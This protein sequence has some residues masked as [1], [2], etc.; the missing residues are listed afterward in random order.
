VIA[1]RPPGRGID[2]GET[3]LGKGSGKLKGKENPAERAAEKTVQGL[4]AG[5][6]SADIVKKKRERGRKVGV[7][8]GRPQHLGRRELRVQS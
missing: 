5:E 8:A 6:G 1:E 4:L 7:Q 3:K 2:A